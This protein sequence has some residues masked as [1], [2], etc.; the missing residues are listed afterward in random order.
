LCIRLSELCLTI[1]GTPLQGPLHEG[2]WFPVACHT[3]VAMRLAVLWVVVS[4]ATQFVF[5]CLPA[6]VFQADVMGKMVA[7]F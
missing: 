4:S 7:Q 5:A 6:E 2:M 3:E 1:V